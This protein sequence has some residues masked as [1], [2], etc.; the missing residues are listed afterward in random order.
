MT[1]FLLDAMPVLIHALELYFDDQSESLWR[2]PAY[3]TGVATSYWARYLYKLPG[4]SQGLWDPKLN[5]PAKNEY[6]VSTVSTL[7]ADWRPYVLLAIQPVLALVMFLCSTWLHTTPFSKGFGM[8][9][10][11]S[12]TQ[13][14]DLKLLSGAAFSGE[15]KRPVKLVISV[16]NDRC[17]QGEDQ[18]SPI[19]KVQYNVDGIS[20]SRKGLQKRILYS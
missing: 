10:I 8:V 14:N 4:S 20:S 6:I 18:N 2:F 15:L 19:G 11:M 3:T 12:G 13:R 1:P 5:Y 17:D 9:A 16:N 7:R